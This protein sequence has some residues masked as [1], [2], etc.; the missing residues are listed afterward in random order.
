MTPPVVG[1]HGDVRRRGAELEVAA[2]R[3]A[4]ASA[5][6]SVVR[7]FMGFNLAV[8]R[9]DD[10]RAPGEGG[11]CSAKAFDNQAC[12]RRGAVFTVMGLVT[13]FIS[14]GVWRK[15]WPQ[16]FVKAHAEWGEID[17]RHAFLARHGAHR[18]GVFT[19]AGH[20]AA[21]F[22]EVAAFG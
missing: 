13:A 4:A 15:V 18:V 20:D 22:I 14:E 2:S 3:E 21:V 10:S 6:R 8:N 11:I 12:E 19:E 16:L 1:A 7:S 9:R 5:P 17:E